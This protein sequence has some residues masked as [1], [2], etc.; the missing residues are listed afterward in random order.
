MRNII[1]AVVFTVLSLLSSLA[2]S[3]FRFSF[4]FIDHAL[5]SGFCYVLWAI[6]IINT[7]MLFAALRSAVPGSG[8][9]NKKLFIFNAALAVLSI[10]VTVIFLIIGNKELTNYYYMSKSL[11]PY[12]AAVFGFAFLVIVFPVFG[13]TGKAVTAAVGAAAILISFF[14]SVVPVKGF[15]FEARPA[16]FDTGDGYHIVFATSYDS[17]GYVK[18]DTADGE[19]VMWDTVTGRK[20]D[21]R[22][23][24]IKV[25]YDELNGKNYTVGA[26]RVIEDSAYGGHLGK[27]ITMDIDKF[28]PCREDDFKMVCITDNHSTKVQWE[29]IS[30][31]AD[32]VAYLGD[33]SNGIYDENNYINDFIAPLG[34]VSSGTKPVI[35][36]RGNHDHRG[37]A[38]PQLIDDLDFEKF[39]YTLNIGKY[40]FTVFDSGEDKEDENWEYAGFND[41]ASYKAEQFDWAKSLDKRSGYN[42]I[43]AHS[44]EIFEAVDK[45]QYPITDVMKNLGSDFVICGHWHTTEYVSAEKS[46]NGI[47]C[48]ICGSYDGMHGLNYTEMTFSG[49]NID[50]VSKNMKGEKPCDA[51][52]NLTETAK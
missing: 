41:Y 23:H 36:A 30:Q 22:V 10:V 50:I 52:V 27:E 7:F 44:Y 21:G 8:H 25:K 20:D 19:K 46:E 32:V 38:V 40:N 35:Y 4:A 34:D 37:G 1:L 48:Y 28:T 49:G 13:K 18:L 11:L 31:D 9:Y 33:M 17:L 43:I 51:K 6:F 14:V 5:F 42:V 3:G 16:V 12:L 15:K 26:V 2:F 45:T 24:S 39:Y 47:A 29:S